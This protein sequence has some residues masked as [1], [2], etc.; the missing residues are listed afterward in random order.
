MSLRVMD[1]NTEL[2]SLENVTPS[3]IITTQL[4]PDL[5]PLLERSGDHILRLIAS[6]KYPTQLQSF[7]SFVHLR[8]VTKEPRSHGHFI[9]EWIEK[10]P[11]EIK[12]G[13]FVQR[14]LRIVN[15]HHDTGMVTAIVD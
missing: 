8:Y 15:Q 2:L 13:E 11:L 9:F 5:H 3:S 7:D 6:T 12:E 1:G 10:K 4:Y 14:T